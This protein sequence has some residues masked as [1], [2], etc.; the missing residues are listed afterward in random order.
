M[1]RV[2]CETTP[3]IIEILQN[4]LDAWNEKLQQVFEIL[5]TSPQ[6]FGGGVVYNTIVDINGAMQSIGLSL[7]VIFV[8]VGILKLNSFEEVKKPERLLKILLQF[9]IGKAIISYGMPLMTEIFSVGMGIIGKMGT[10]QLARV[11]I[12]PDIVSAAQEASFL[13]TLFPSVLAL[14]GSLVM[15]VVSLMILLTVF[16]RLFKV[17]MY[18]AIAPIPLS[19]FAGESTKHV[20]TSFL[21]SF[22]GVCLEGAL[23]MLA[24]IIYTA[25]IGTA[26][27]PFA[28]GG[29]LVDMLYSYVFST[30]MNML[31]LL[32]TIKACDRI[33]REM[34]GL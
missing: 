32:G 1:E 10:T 13:D 27:S 8:L 34:M 12:A 7:L 30:V 26:E 11:E 33:V 17:Y 29:S 14:I 16:G 31:I 6:S 24:C 18:I 2:L 4:A 5:T 23:I 22:A 19:T 28:S 3:W 9:V 21:K 25:Y 20:G 15:S